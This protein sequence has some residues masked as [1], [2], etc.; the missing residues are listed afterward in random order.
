MKKVVLPLTI[1]ACILISGL[2]AK[3]QYKNAFG[4][5]LGDSYGVTFKTFLQSDKALD[6]ILNVRNH[7]DIGYFRLT[8]LYEVHNPI[9]G[10]PGLRWYYG[11]GG[12]LGSLH[13]KHD[14]DR[15]ND[16]YL[17]VD[18][19]LGLDYKLDGAPLN[20]SLDWKPALVLNPYTDFDPNG[21]GLSVRITF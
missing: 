12:T 9:A 10:A 16:L 5:R 18:G 2:S 3:A 17:S 11:G 6:F 8:G 20:F 19:V 14:N 15:D 7:N 4:V 1:T 13:Y 21:V